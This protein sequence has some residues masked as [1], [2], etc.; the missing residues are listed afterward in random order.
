MSIHFIDAEDP[1]VLKVIKINDKKPE[2]EL[3]LISSKEGHGYF[4]IAQGELVDIEDSKVQVKSLF[5]YKGNTV[6]A[7]GYSQDGL[8]YEKGKTT[9]CFPLAD[10]PTILEEWISV[11]VL[12]G[13][14]L[15]AQSPKSAAA[16]SNFMVDATKA[17]SHLMA[18][19]GET[20]FISYGKEDSESARRL[21]KD[22]RNAGLNPWLDEEK[23]S[24]GTIWKNAIK[25][26]IKD[27]RYFIALFSSKTVNRSGFVH[28]EV[29]QALDVL[30][31][32]P[33]SIIYLI[34][35]RLDKCNPS[36]DKLSELQ[37]VDM[38]PDWTEGIEKILSSFQKS[39]EDPYELWGHVLDVRTQLNIFVPQWHIRRGHEASDT[40]IA[41]HKLERLVEKVSPFIPKELHKRISEFHGLAKK[42]FTSMLDWSDIEMQ[43]FSPDG[44]GGMI[45]TKPFDYEPTE[46]P[47]FEKEI[48]LAKEQLDQYKAEIR[49]NIRQFSGVE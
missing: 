13:I 4:N 26:A 10:D 17:P 8:V 29:S 38:F 16:A 45:R 36:H 18:N 14:T 28:K 25:K 9:V 39:E 21:Y 11:F 22:L 46:R 37:R 6:I 20:I 30:E 7:G 12:D 2:D 33:E 34:P 3:L 40:W 27:S 5:K 41:I 31:S 48:A 35:V 42:T 32:Y 44:S 1:E 49:E 47:I 24:P 43:M 19:T 15:F 23:L